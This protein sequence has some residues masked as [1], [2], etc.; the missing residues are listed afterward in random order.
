MTVI[1]DEQ[2]IDQ[3]K[4]GNTYAI[5]DLYRRYAKKLFMFFR[6]IMHA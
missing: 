1:S 2:L 4:D 6:H 3:R 5:D